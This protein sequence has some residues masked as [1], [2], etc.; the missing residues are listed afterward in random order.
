M[1]AHWLLGA[2]LFLQRVK[3]VNHDEFKII[4]YNQNQINKLNLHV[5]MK[6]V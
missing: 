1:L 5:D 6:T 4:W 2:L 3:Y